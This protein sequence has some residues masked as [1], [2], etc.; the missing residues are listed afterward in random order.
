MKKFKNLRE[1]ATDHKVPKKDDEKNMSK[2]DVEF[3]D[4]HTVETDDHPVATDA[5]HPK[6]GKK[7][8]SGVRKVKAKE[9][10]DLEEATK[11][12]FLDLDEAIKDYEVKIKIGSKTNSY[13][14]TAKDELSAAQSVLHSVMAR[15][16]TGG[17][18]GL[19][20]VRKQF[21]DMKSLK[22]KG[23]LLN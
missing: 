16:R 1:A 19:D 7:K 10:V 3:A 14:M 22:K 20:A 18:P 9:E 15:S 4:L 5:Q 13:T 21:P 12:D 17:S 11:P 6:K 2:N 23:I 8:F